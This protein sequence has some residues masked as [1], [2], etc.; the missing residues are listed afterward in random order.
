MVR[1][2]RW[3]ARKENEKKTLTE[4]LFNAGIE[5]KDDISHLDHEIKELNNS[6]M[7]IEADMMQLQ[8]QV[9]IYSREFG[10]KNLEL[11]ELTPPVLY[12]KADLLDGM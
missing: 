5:N 7:K 12:L 3:N 8:T 11:P 2:G 9:S 4:V 6:N 10:L 1:L